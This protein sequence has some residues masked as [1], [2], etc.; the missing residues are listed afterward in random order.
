MS[1]ESKSQACTSLVRPISEYGSSAWDPYRA[2]QKNWLKQVQQHA[3]RLATKTYI[4]GRK[5]V[6][7]TQALIHLIGQN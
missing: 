1:R 4:Q 7:N 6:F 2:Y 3:A 5:D